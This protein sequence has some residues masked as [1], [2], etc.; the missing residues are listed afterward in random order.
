[1]ALTVKD[2]LELPSGQKM[3]IIS[4]RGGLNKVVISV[5][6]ADYEFVPDV[7]HITKKPFAIEE[8]LD[9]GSFIV[10]S[11]LFAKDD[12]DVIL[13]AVKKMAELGIS[14]LAFKSII[15]DELPPEVIAFSESEGFP[16][17]SFGQNVWFENIIFDIMYA[18]QFDDKVYLAEK[19]IDAML[20]GYMEKTELDI[21]LKGI[22]LKL[23]KYISVMR[24]YGETLDA[25]RIL[26]SFYLLKGFH[27]KGLVVQYGND[28]FLIITSPSL[29]IKKH[30]LI[31]NDLFEVLGIGE[32]ISV[33]MS[34]VHEPVRMDT[35]FRESSFALK[36][37][38]IEDKRSVK[39]ENAGLYQVLVPALSRPE[40]HAFAEK[41]LKEIKKSADLLE[42][43]L[44]YVTCGGDVLRTAERLCCHGNTVRY[45]LSRIREIAGLKGVT[46]SELYAQL[47]TAVII[48]K[49]EK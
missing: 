41:T 8:A 24:I 30:E 21:I 47:K 32:E 13:P 45:R 35:A 34:S 23:N 38:L 6:I 27:S 39:F 37:A 9:P 22:S 25:A 40:S 10:T 48:D 43:S 4:G 7:E 36:A 2:I 31:G 26:R 1:M 18:V 42:T 44:M 19:K 16:I 28:I 12:P 17:L 49:A 3:N 46:D 20:A 14:A 33:G 29:D 15:Y 11:F 5:E